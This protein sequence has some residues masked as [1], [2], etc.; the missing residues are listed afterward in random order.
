MQFKQ[1]IDNYLKKLPKMLPNKFFVIYLGVLLVLL[2]FQIGNKS[3]VI[4]CREM[5]VNISCEIQS[6]S[7]QNPTDARQSNS[8]VSILQN[9]NFNRL[10]QLDLIFKFQLA[11]HFLM[12]FFAFLIAFLISR[13]IQ[14]FKFFYQ[15]YIKSS[16]PCRAGPIAKRGDTFFI[17]TQ[18][19]G[20]KEEK[21]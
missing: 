11:G 7:N 4:D 8:T 2:F 12:T 17:L 19:Y 15:M 13:Q 14:F 6:S 10:F 21:N 20:I 1:T 3:T 18:I 16:I 5:P 9:F